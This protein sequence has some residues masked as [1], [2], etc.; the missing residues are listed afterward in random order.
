M[1]R[2]LPAIATL[3]G[4]TVLAPA[5]AAPQ[6]AGAAT[7]LTGVDPTEHQVISEINRYRRANRLRALR[8]EPRL[9]AAA[10]WM[11]RDMASHS[12]VS[13]TDRLGR[14]PFQRI[15]S[16]RYP[17]NTRRGENLA[18][19]PSGARAVFVQWRNSPTH[20]ANLLSRTYRAVGVSRTFNP[21][22]ASGYYWTLN[23]G[24]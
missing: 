12:Y 4:F 23:F 14:S 3:T 18:A 19:G 15:A 8:L 13:H 20:R 16:F 5:M 7:A 17:G 24:S 6:V 21:R 11:S 2:H 9:T 10:D 1:W 22:S